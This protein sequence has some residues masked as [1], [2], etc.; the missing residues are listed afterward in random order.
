[1]IEKRTPPELPGRQ[2]QVFPFEVEEIRGA[3]PEDF[4]ELRAPTNVAKLVTV[5]GLASVYNYEYPVYG[6]PEAGGWYERV[7]NT[8][9]DQTLSENPDV[10]FLA[11]HVGLPMA[12][13]KSGTLNLSAEKKGLGARSTLDPRDTEASN[14]LVKMDRGDVDE[15][16][17][18][19]RTVKQEWQAHKK[20]PQDEMS[21][22]TLL[23]LNL[24]RGDVSA[25][26]F[27]ASDATHIKVE[28]SAEDLKRSLSLVNDDELEELQALIAERL[29]KRSTPDG[30][31][32][33]LP[34]AG[35]IPV[36]MLQM[37]RL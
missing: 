21:L 19:F 9:F 16:S 36:H 3:V 15:M 35:G 33:S 8:A 25:V 6:G 13:T 11:N 1:M 12:R 23:E 18:A 10:V 20:Y 29:S 14:L 22:R 5:R 28:R 30:M 34:Q 26:T 31:S 24:H 4:G 37:L 7:A 2:T 17:F 32:E 27:G